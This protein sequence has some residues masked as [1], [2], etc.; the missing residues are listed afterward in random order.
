MTNYIFYDDVLE[1]RAGG[2]STY[3]Y[4]LKKGLDKI[5]T[6]IIHFICRKQ[7][8]KV[9]NSESKIKKIL[10]KTPFLYERFFIK[11][12]QQISGIYEQLNRVKLND[13]VMFHMTTDFTKSLKLLPKSCTKVLM[14]HS[15]EIT[16]YQIVNDLKNRTGKPNY[17]FN[18]ARKKYYEKFDLPAFKNA[19][20]LVFPSKEAME[21]YYETC[22][23]FEKIIKDKKIKFL[24]TGT[25]KLEFKMSKSKFRKK[26]RI[27]DNA[28]V[29]TFIGRHNHV[30]GYDIFIEI[31]KSLINKYDDC[32]IVTAGVGDIKSYNHERWIDIGWTNDPGSVANAADIFVL[33]N[34]RTYFDLVLIEMLSIGKTCLVSNTGGNKTMA[35]YSKG[36]ITYDSIE[37][38]I[39][40]IIYMYLNRDC[41]KKY[42]KLNEN[43]YIENFTP[44]IFSQRYINLMREIENEK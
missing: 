3:L 25:E 37:D 23:N 4:N 29:L 5:D 13:T 31:C 44:E 21:P 32:Y 38:A 12:R 33:P 14:S 41:L 26:Y 35:T 36:I 1:Q 10:Y 18:Y 2:P 40:K 24:P 20:I 16:S 27:P 15:P 28:F 39:N 6:N 7:N 17:K 42:S 9:V 19:D 34:R 22:D 30:K 11:R 43:A 8:S